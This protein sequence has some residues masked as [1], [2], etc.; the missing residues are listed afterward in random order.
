MTERKPPGVPFESWVER[1]IA[2]AVRRGDFDDLPGAGKPLPPGDDD[3]SWW[4]RAYLQREE[5]EPG[6]ALPTALQ[7]RREADEIDA[8]V[9]DLPTEEEVRRTVAGLN[10]RVV[11]SWRQP[12]DS[13]FVARLVNVERVVARWRAARP[14]PRPE[15]VPPPEPPRRRRWWRLRS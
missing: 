3:E 12:S 2:E 13:R 7:L 8:T 14:V 15:L 6:T 9:R 4:L 1:Q 11:E 5:V 10:A